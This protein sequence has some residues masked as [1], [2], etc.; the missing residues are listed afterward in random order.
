MK[1]HKKIY[2]ICI[3][4]VACL[5][6]AAVLFWWQSTRPVSNEAYVSRIQSLTPAPQG[7]VPTPRRD[8]T[9]AAISLDGVDFVGVLEIPRYDSALPVCAQWGSRTQY[10]CCFSGSVYDGT[11]RIGATSRQG[12]YDFY[13]EI[14][15]GD[16]IYFTDMEGNRY[17]FTVSDLRYEKKADQE[18]LSRNNADL[19]LFIKNVY[20]F[21]YLIVYCNIPV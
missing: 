16:S 10:P 13:R 7:A 11:L 21:D 9:M 2:G 6:I 1:K 3:L 12:Q 18:T 4:W 5:L 19:I 17:A 20:G 15:V 14:S 8:N